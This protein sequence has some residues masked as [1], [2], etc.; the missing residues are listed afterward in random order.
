MPTNHGRFTRRDFTRKAAIAAV[1]IGIGVGTQAADRATTGMKITIIGDGS[2]IPDVGRETA[3]FLIDGKHLVDTGWCAALNMRLYGLDP[4]SLESVIFT[5]FHQDHYLGLPQL[6]FYVGL[7]KRNGPPLNIIG[8]N[9]HLKQVVNAALAFLQVSRFPE[10][11]PSY[12]L[13][14]LAAGDSFDLPSLRLETLAAKHVSSRGQREQAL[15][16]RVTEKANGACVVFTGDTSYHPPIAEFA[17]GAPLLLHDGAHTS[18][19]DA[20]SIA[21]RARVGRLALIHYGQSQAGRILAE[22]RAIFPR[23]ELAKEGCT[24]EVAA[25]R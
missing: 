17:R 13:V 16:Y 20:A 25:A 11:T 22:A 9:E 10:V 2:C 5:H 15:V 8:P 4:L 12:T 6:L 7:H 21:L 24:L 18:A 14:P 19:R 1:G 3:C 23:T